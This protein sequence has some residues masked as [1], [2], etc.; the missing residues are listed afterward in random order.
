MDRSQ[1][2]GAEIRFDVQGADES[3][4]VFTTRPDTLFGATYCVLAPEHPL[5]TKITTDAHRDDVQRYVEQATHKK[6]RDRIADTKDKTGVFTGAF[7]INPV[8]GAAIPIW[9]ADYVLASYGTGAIM[10]VPAHD[11]RDFDF[12]RRFE[13]PIIPVVRARATVRSRPTWTEAFAAAGVACNSGEYDGLETDAFKTKIIADLEAKGV[14]KGR[15]QYALRDW[16]FSRQRYWGEPF[17]LITL[18]DGTPSPSPMTP[19]PSNSP[20]W[21]NSCPPRTA[22]PPLARATEWRKVTDPASGK[23]GLR[24][25]NTMPQWAGSCWYYLRFIDPKNENEPWDR[26]KERYWMPVDLYI[27]GM[28]HAVLHLLY[29]RFWHKVLYD[30]EL[31]STKEPFKKLF[32][33]GM[34][35]AYSYTDENDRYYH[36]DDVEER[37][38]A[39]F[40]KA[41]GRPVTTQIEKMSKSRLNVV[42]PDDVV[43]LFGA[44][45]LR[46][47]E[48]FIGPL[49]QSAPWQTQGIE[50]V[51]RFLHRSWRL[52]CEGEDDQLHPGIGDAAPDEGDRAPVAQDDQE[53]HRR[54]RGASV[55][56]R[57]LGPDGTGESPD[58]SEGSFAFRS[59][60]LRPPALAVRAAHRRGTLAAPGP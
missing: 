29:A 31:V 33:Q 52:V 3:F 27:G 10:A 8:N 48:M 35:L 60:R 23:P 47:Y 13:L 12:A 22:E 14:G 41:D 30:L 57:H 59:D 21:T 18:E 56:H 34:I 54:H 58:A 4:T 55:Q 45:S 25:V 9:V 15:V 38:G 19:C 6:E 43:D 11:Q 17:P 24:E 20:R 28:E 50:G 53:G 42:N 44:D 36:P 16:L 5:V 51:H 49:E 2:E 32:N 39:W 7:A 37:D 1:S 40:T 46:L 26:E